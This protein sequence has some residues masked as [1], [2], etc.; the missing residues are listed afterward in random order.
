VLRPNAQ[1]PDI[2]KGRAKVEP[3]SGWGMLLSKGS[4]AR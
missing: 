2:L 3:Q 1:L 4:A